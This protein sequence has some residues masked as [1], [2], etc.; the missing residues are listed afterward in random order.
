MVKDD[1]SG[2]LEIPSDITGVIYVQFD[3]SDGWKLKLVK[4]LK[5]SGYHVS[6][7]DLF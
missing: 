1:P 5:A 3:G 4:S 2:L 7:D 6:A